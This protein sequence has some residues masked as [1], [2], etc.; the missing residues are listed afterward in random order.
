MEV[1]I[2]KLRINPLFIA[3]G[4]VLFVL[5]QGFTFIAYFIAMVAHEMAHSAMAAHF[6]YLLDDVNLMPYGA[7]LS[8]ETDGMKPREEIAVALAGPLAGFALAI[9]F[10]ALWWLAPSTYFFTET[11]V[12]ANFMTSAFNLLPV[13][14]LDGG[15]VALALLSRK[16]PRGK[17]MRIMKIGGYAAAGAFMALCAVSVFFAFNVTYAVIAFFM[18]TGTVTAARASSYMRIKALASRVGAL[19]KGLTVREVCISENATLFALNKLMQGSYFYKIN[20]MNDRLQIVKI[21]DEI[22]FE[23]LTMKNDLYDTVGKALKRN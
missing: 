19:K 3:L 5:G 6:G 9:I 17:A 8:G 4:V 22:A 18:L 13:F 2:V 7:A 15:R 23:G 14:P 10:T 1:V 20:V 11:F 16:T 21:F 12:L